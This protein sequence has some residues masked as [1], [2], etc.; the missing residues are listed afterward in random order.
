MPREFF[1]EGPLVRLSREFDVF[2]PMSSDPEPWM[3]AEL[4]QHA[5]AVCESITRDGAAVTLQ[6]LSRYL[7]GF[8][9][10]CRERGWDSDSSGYDWET[11]RLLAVCRLAKE[12]GFVR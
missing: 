10:G 11:L 8:I 7:H 4:D 6:S 2:G 12:H 9:D 3:T 1:A 5:A